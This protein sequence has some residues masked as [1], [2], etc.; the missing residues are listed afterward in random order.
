MTRRMNETEKLMQRKEFIFLPGMPTRD[1]NQR[2]GVIHNTTHL[3]NDS[4]I[5]IY[6]LID[7][8][9]FEARYIGK[10]IG[11]AARLTNHMNETKPCHRTNWLQKL[12]RQGMIPFIGILEEVEDCYSWE[13]AEKWWIAYG[14][15]SGW[16]LTNGTEGGDGV[17]GLSPESRAKMLKTWTGRKHKPETIA[18]LCIARRLRKISQATRKKM[19]QSQKGRKITWADKLSK[20]NRK[21]SEEA[22]SAIKFRLSAGEKVKDLSVEFGVHRTTISKIKMGTYCDRYRKSR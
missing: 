11:P 4:I 15:A 7:P 10:S 16:P 19:S 14:K 6:V 2:P 22:V 3:K 1:P 9:T 17:S 18:K 21:L 8:E 5:Y 13:T 12:K 20:A